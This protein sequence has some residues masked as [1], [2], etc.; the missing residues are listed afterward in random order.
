M[1]KIILDGMGGDNAPAAVVEGA[2]IALNRD[3]NLYIIITGRKN[4]IE[5]ELAKYKYDKDRL[6]IMDCPDVI[7]MNDIPTVAIK[8]RQTEKACPCN[9]LSNLKL[10]KKLMQLPVPS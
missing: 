5:A 3:K 7:G 9:L 6:E 10:F 8:N 2:T 4:E 1:D